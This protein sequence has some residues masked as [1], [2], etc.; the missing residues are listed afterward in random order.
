MLASTADDDL[1]IYTPERYVTGPPHAAFERL[2]HEDPVHWQDTP[3]GSWYW[4]VL[5]HADVVHVARHPELFSAS[6]G[7]VVIEDLPPVM[8]D[9]LLAMD[10]PR[11]LQRRQNVA[12]PFSPRAVAAL[13]PRVRA[14]TRDVLAGVSD[15]G[16]VEVVHDV[17]SHIPSQVVGE[18]VGI[19]RE[20]WPQIHRWSERTSG[21]QDPDIATTSAGDAATATVDMALYA[22][23]LAAQRRARPATT[24]SRCCWPPRS[25]GTR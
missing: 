4:A 24:S 10:P 9:M 14:I 23:E 11:H 15:R 7:G 12:S 18:L 16:D 17:C 1:D 3:D 8:R 21:G 2:R 13:E 6:R 25:T 5:R 20:D 22:I 19:P